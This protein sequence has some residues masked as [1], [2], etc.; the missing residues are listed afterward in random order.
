MSQKDTIIT[1]TSEDGLAGK[2]AQT[3]AV[4][5][6]PSS[7]VPQMVNFAIQIVIVNEIVMKINAKV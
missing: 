6:Q 7:P 5:M 2:G 3:G 1:S 4:T